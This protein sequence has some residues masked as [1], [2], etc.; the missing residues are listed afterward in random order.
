MPVRTATRARQNTPIRTDD[1]DLDIRLEADPEPAEVPRRSGAR[2]A[3]KLAARP[4]KKAPG[5]PAKQDKIAKVETEI[6]TYLSLA[7]GVWEVMD[8]D[9][10][11]I[12]TEQCVVPGDRGPVTMERLEAI[13]NRLVKIAAKNERVLNVLAQSA[14]LGDIGVLAT[15]LRPVVVQVYRHHGPGRNRKGRGVDLDGFPSYDAG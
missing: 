7:V 1:P 13:T 4:A 14:V 12:L 15:L 2:A 8:P 11:S 6:Y 9:C 3:S 5:R 10:A